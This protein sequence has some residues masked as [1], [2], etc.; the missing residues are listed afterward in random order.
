MTDSLATV[1]I[2][3]YNGRRFLPRL[4]ESLAGQSEQ[5]FATLVVDDAS[6]QDDLA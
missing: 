1:I 2:P 4:M 5:R 3:N 6:P